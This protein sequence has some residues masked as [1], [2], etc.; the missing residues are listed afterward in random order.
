MSGD[1][2]LRPFVLQCD[3]CRTVIGDSF[4]V[5]YGVSELRSVVLSTV[6]MVDIEPLSQQGGSEAIMCGHCKA[7]LGEILRDRPDAAPAG[8]YLIRLSATRTYTL[9][10]T[11]PELAGAHSTAAV[12]NGADRLLAQSLVPTA[13]SAAHE[14]EPVVVKMQQMLINHSERIALLEAQLERARADDRGHDQHGSGLAD[15]R[16]YKR[17]RRPAH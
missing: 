4:S 1:E 7:P 15:K 3:Q 17:G 10:S 13:P 8:Q 11:A 2:E 5:E 12:A 14:D 6:Q 16:G 9:G